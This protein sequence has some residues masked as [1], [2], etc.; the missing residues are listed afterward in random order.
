MKNILTSVIVSV[1]V[2]GLALVLFKPT[3]VIR[4]IT[5]GGAS[6]TLHSNREFFAQGATLG[7]MVSTTTAISTY[8]S[9]AENFTQLPTVISWLPNVNLT[10]S[11]GSTSTLPLIPNVGDTATVYFRNASTTAASTVTFA[12]ADTSVDMQFTEATGGDLVLNGL[13]W[14]KLTFI[15][16]STSGTSQVTVIFDEMTEAD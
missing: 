11:I 16:N 3:Q 1:V 13:D 6:G 10:Y 15:R 7:G 2:V 9:Q 5:A 4:N 12:A 14:A 8:T